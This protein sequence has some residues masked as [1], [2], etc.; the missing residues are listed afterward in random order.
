MKKSL[1]NSLVSGALLALSVGSASA[2]S[3]D[4]FLAPGATFDQIVSVTPV[5]DN[6][7][8]FQVSGALSQFSSISFQFLS[9]PINVVASNKNGVLTATFN[10]VRNASYSLPASQSYNVRVVA[11]A[12]SS[13]SGS[14]A[15][16]TVNAF[17]STVT[18]VPEPETYAMFLAG[19]GLMGAVA[20]RRMIKQA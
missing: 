10:D 20:R 18:A 13:F 5:A 9:Q 3:M 8:Q 6:S 11:T 4:V 1:I 17:A 7:L 15:G 14:T 16:L 12:N 19:L 2:N